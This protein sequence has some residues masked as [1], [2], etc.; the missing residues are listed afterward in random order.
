VLSAGLDANGKIVGWSHKTSGSSV[1]ARYSPEG[2]NGALDPD[3]VE[4]AANSP[5]DLPAVHV[6]YVRAE[7][8]GVPTAWW[9][10][11]GPTHNVFVVE[12]FMDECAAAAGHDPVEYRRSMLQR[13]PRALAVLNLAAE[14]S[15]WGEKLPAGHGRG[16]SLQYAFSSFMAVVLHAEVTEK[17]EILLHRAVA[18]IDCGQRVNPDTIAAQIEGGL[19]FGLGTA[20]YSDVTLAHGRVQQSNFNNYKMIRIN[21][22]PKIEV[23]QTDSTEQ[24]G[25]IGE[26]GTAASSAALGNAI[27]A[28][29]GRRLRQLPFAHQVKEVG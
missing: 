2:M 25:G 3:A 13:N 17:G 7:P 26:T 23:F 16:V 4:G 14:K 11:V 6:S 1:T 8:Q 24:P 21:Q 12:S 27:F 5:Y 22:A 28:A 10:G 9:R 18:A 20:M 29:T 19:I 15:G